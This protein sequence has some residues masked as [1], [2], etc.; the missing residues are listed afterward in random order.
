MKA[1]D[2][3]AGEAG[4][5]PLFD[6]QV[7]RELHESWHDIRDHLN[8]ILGL[9]SRLLLQSRDAA[10]R[11]TPLIGEQSDQLR[12]LVDQLVEPATRRRS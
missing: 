3:Q 9:V 2:D 12:Y 11:L 5:V 7:L 10:V 8:A 6:A 1:A 4:S